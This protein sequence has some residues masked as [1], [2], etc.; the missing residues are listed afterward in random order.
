DALALS[1]GTATETDNAGFSVELM[2]PGTRTFQEVDFVPGAGTTS[3]PRTYTTR[4]TGLEAGTY[5]VRLRQVDFDGAFEYSPTAEVTLELATSYALSSVYPNPFNPRALV[6]LTVQS[7]QVVVAQLYDLLGQPVRRLFGGVVSANAPQTL[8]IDGT[9]L[10][11]GHYFIRLDGQT[12]S[13]SRKVTL[14]R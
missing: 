2:R 11:S 13:V 3:E 8:A 5:H 10:P 7:D 6:T 4:V 12:F 14:L 1:W 9:G